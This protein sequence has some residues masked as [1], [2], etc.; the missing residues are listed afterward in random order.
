[1]ARGRIKL[2]AYYFDVGV[3]DVVILVLLFSFK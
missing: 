3:G 1:M 2:C